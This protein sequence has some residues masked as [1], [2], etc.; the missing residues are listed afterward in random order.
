M[1]EDAIDWLCIQAERLIGIAMALFVF[2]LALG[3]V[4]AMGAFLGTC[5]MTTWRHW[6]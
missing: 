3:A 6:Q 4:W 1:I 2:A 5:V